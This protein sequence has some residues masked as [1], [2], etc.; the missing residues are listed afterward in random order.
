MK[1]LLTTIC[2]LAPL[3][4]TAA[5]PVTDAEIDLINTVPN[6][7][8]GS[9]HDPSITSTNTDG[10]NTYYVFGSHMDVA[11][12][13]DFKDWTVVTSERADSRLFCDVNG[14]IC[15]FDKAYSTNKVT[16][17][18]NY[19]GQ[20]VDWGTFNIPAYQGAIDNFSVKGNQWAPDMIYNPQMK[21]WCYYMSLNGS[22]WNSAI[23]LF[24]SDHV[25][26]P[27][28]YQG[29]IIFSGFNVTSNAATDYKKTDLQIA[30]GNQNT[31][32]ARYNVGEKWG[33]YWP[34]AIDPGV[35]FDE[36]GDL[37]MNYG[38]WSGG[39]YI[40]KLD[41]KTGLRDYTYKYDSNFETKNASVTTD[42]YFGK[43][44]AGGYYVSGEGSYIEKIGKYYYLFISYGFYS[45]EGGYEMRVFRSEQPDGPY[46][47]HTGESAIYNKYLMNYGTKA[48]TNRGMKLMGGY[49]W[50]GMD[51]AEI[52]QG[53]NSAL[54][55]EDG[56][57]MLFYHTKLNNGTIIHQ[58]R[59][60]QLFV[61]E[62]GWITAA[63][64]EY[65]K[66]NDVATTSTVGTQRFFSKAEI[67]G[68]YNLILHKYNV[69]Y[70][71][72]EY[73][74]PVGITL[75]SDGSV[76]GAYTG[77]W[78]LTDGTSY[79]SLTLN[80]VT[81][82]GVV[83]PGS[84][85]ATNVPVVAITAMSTSNGVNIWASKPSGK[86]CI[87]KDIAAMDNLQFRD[88]DSIYGN[89]GF[90]GLTT[91]NGCTINWNSGNTD[92]VDNN[93]TV[94]PQDTDTP[95]NMTAALQKGDYEYTKTVEV[96]VKGNGTANAD[97]VTGL[98]AY[99]NFDHN[100]VNQYNE[101]Q[102]GTANAQANGTKPTFD[103]DSE[104]GTVL[105]QYFGY[106][107]AKSISYTTFSNPLAGQK[108]TGATVS[109]WVKRLNGDMWD[110]LWGFCNSYGN[111]TARYYLTGNTYIGYNDGNG[112]W[113]DYNYPESAKLNTIPQE[114]WALVTIS[115]NKQGF[116]L[117]INGKFVANQSRYAAYNS[118]GATDFSAQLG[119]LSKS[120]NFYLG[121]G[122]FWGS[123]PALF[124]DLLIW[125]RALSAA[126][127]ARLYVVEST[128]KSLMPGKITN[129][130]DQ[131]RNELVKSAE[132]QLY[133]NPTSG[134][135]SIVFPNPEA[136]KV[137][138][139]NGCGQV[140]CRQDIGSSQNSLDLNLRPGIYAIKVESVTSVWHKQIIVK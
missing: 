77:K 128:G 23:V 137:T 73:S 44:I 88:G 135:V 69:D 11:K 106:D 80:N 35:F 31:L 70:A 78:S 40:I 83:V 52:A 94:K 8:R 46:T 29:P 38:S 9:V 93:G 81:Y 110:A 47:D 89:I 61:N 19:A 90:V 42:A 24:T 4:G 102:T 117:Y 32:P 74:K 26:G 109:A 16:S 107:D 85:D 98:V 97:I 86:A 64:H 22:K 95:V 25:E 84:L 54:M 59:V 124:D 113:F 87:A 112:T 14:N 30:I 131:T 125:N 67:E 56:N 49:Q 96:V 50:A 60:H 10:K 101:A 123:T 66:D 72:Y 34:H 99:Y 55:D 7:K 63:P 139:Y 41:K 62:D 103:T 6:W 136:V 105:H 15:S 71:N 133:P 18:T 129:E 51:V 134:E 115:Y 33:T 21:K 108:L 79:I 76:S 36:N 13:T 65:N 116:D 114:E 91:T 37:W 58:L 2:A 119:H 57:A 28:Q 120:T 43:K 5:I 53:H 17:V 3:A 48:T 45:P 75:N 130:D 1:R 100:L 121:Y 138:I 126:D 20:T 82:K 39:I 118:S 111:V 68:T 92:V 122:S 104:R 132:P 127:V 27:F 12:T 140:V